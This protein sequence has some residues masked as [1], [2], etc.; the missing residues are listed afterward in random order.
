[1]NKVVILATTDVH[2]CVYAHS[3]ADASIQDYG[4]TRFS[5]A[6]KQ[7]RDQGEVYVLDNGDIL[8]GTPFLTTA[9]QDDDGKHVLSRIMNAIGYDFIN[10]GNHD[11]NYGYPVLKRYLDDT[12]ATCLTSNI[13][14]QDHALGSSRL[15]TTASGKIIALIGVCTDYIPHWEK[16]ENIRDMTFLDPFATVK[17]EI[18][19]LTPLADRIVVMY[20]GGVERDPDSGKLT[21]RDTGENIGYRLA[22]LEGIDIL[23]T[24]HQHRSF[25]C[26]INSTQVV[27]TTYNALEFAEITID[28]DNDPKARLKIVKMKDFPID[29]QI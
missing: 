19:R 8:Q 11:F 13:S 9:N 5:T 25:T 4:L 28:F 21:Q 16:P 2:G 10:L 14:Y 3:Y 29:S 18:Q 12:Q 22:Q 26:V 17:A 15:I 1:M 23:I 7:Y 6:V 20:H 24:G 27:Q